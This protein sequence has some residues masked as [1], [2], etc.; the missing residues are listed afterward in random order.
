MT[1]STDNPYVFDSNMI[2]VG[3]NKLSPPDDVIVKN[4]LDPSV[5][6]FQNKIR[7]CNV[8][9][10]IIHETVT[11]SWSDTVKV[12]KPK[13]ASNPNGQGLGVHFIV[14]ADGI[15][16]QHGDLATDFL[17][18]ANEHNLKSVGIETVNPYYPK[19]VSKLSPWTD[20][21]DAP[22][23]DGGKYCVP[24]ASQA[25]AVCSLINWLTSENSNLNIEQNWIGVSDNRIAM[26]K[27]SATESSGIYAHHYFDHS[28]GCWLAL[29]TWLRLKANLSV[30]DA[31]MRAIKLATGVRGSID[32][33]DYISS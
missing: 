24:T 11:R 1:E 17:W 14:D 15:I 5:Y 32:L 8:T 2:V 7:N 21:I 33:S 20:F 28:D 23:A 26:G 9:E 16:Y 18:H 13:T 12:L 22:W 4:F 6:H 27:I 25:E 3:G 31:R 29:Y 30:D 10:V 19:Y